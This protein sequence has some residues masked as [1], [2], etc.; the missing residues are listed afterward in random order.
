MSKI[1]RIEPNGLTFDY[2][3]EA[4]TDS[5]TI[6]EGAGVEHSSVIKLI[7]NHI[8][9]VSEFGMV[10]FEIRPFETNGGM[11]KVKICRLNEQQATFVI[12]MM[13]NTKQVIAFKKELVRQFFEMKEFIQTMITTRQDFSLLTEQIKLVHVN[14]K[15]YHFSN[16]CNMINKLVTGMT[17]KQFREK[18]NIKKGESI[19]PYLTP[20]QLTLM[21]KLQKLDYGLLVAVPDYN[22]RKQLLIQCL[23]QTVK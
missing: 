15:P 6:A 20:E 2:K 7:T 3:D 13:K 1:I 14:P 17:T 19:R 16:E 23:K 4:F 18:H 11:Q 21:E 5:M 10:G 22:Q 8:D 12:S 9:D